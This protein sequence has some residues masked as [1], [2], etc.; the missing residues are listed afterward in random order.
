MSVRGYVYVSVV[1]DR[2]HKRVTDLPELQFLVVVIQPLWVLGML[3]ISRVSIYMKK[4]F[5]MYMASDS[6]FL[7]SL[8]LLYV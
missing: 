3:T 7:K 8:Y 1:A 6:L 4:I 2:G 5:S